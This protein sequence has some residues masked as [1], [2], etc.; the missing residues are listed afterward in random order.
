MGD[1]PTGNLDS[2]RSAEVLAML[3]DLNR[4]RGQTIILVTHDPEVGAACDRIVRMLDGLM[5]G[6]ERRVVMPSAGAAA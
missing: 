6:D 5:V 3:R 2:K 1:E 4:E